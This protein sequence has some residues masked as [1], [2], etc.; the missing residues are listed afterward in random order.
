MSS[1]TKK[2]L[3]NMRKE[4]TKT[5]GVSSTAAELS[6]TDRKVW[7]TMG[8]FFFQFKSIIEYHVKY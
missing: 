7:E 1:E 5:G 8:I 2:R 6:G 3:S 4:V